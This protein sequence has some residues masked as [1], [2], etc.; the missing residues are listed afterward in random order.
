MTNPYTLVFGQPPLE[1]VERRPQSDRIISDFCS[2]RPA[3]YINLVTGIRGSG[4]TVFIT[5]IADRIQEKQD[6]IVINLNAQRDMLQ[7]FAAKLNSHQKLQSIFREARIDLSFLGIGVRLEGAQPI[8]DIETAITAMLQ[9]VKKQNKRVLVTVDEVSNN[10]EM[11]IFASSFQI[12]LREKLPVFLLMTG[13]YKNIDHLRNADGMTFLER[14]PRTVLGPLDFEQIAEKYRTTLGLQPDKANLLAR[15]T[16]GYSFAFQVF[17]YYFW[18]YSGDEPLA[19]QNAISYLSEF[20]YRKIWSELS[21]RDREVVLAASQIPD[22]RIA[23]I[24]SLLGW[25]SNQFNPYRDRLIKAGILQTPEPGSVEFS[26]PY[27]GEYARKV[28]ADQGLNG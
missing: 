12:F 11:R 20:A 3:N 4:K 8:T 6:W 15:Q 5:D 2:A 26:L 1:I 10:K 18:E 13:L 21:S 25:S 16:R 22:G 24:R 23:S 27:F 19:V 28:T 7:S 14:A 9:S 17:G